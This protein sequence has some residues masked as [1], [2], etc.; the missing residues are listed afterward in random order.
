MDPLLSH[1]IG[2]YRIDR[3][4]GEGGMGRVYSG[5]NVVSRRVVAIKVIADEHANSADLVGRFYAEAEA[6]S[7]IRHPG[8]VEVI[9]LVYLVDGR[10]AIV[11]ELL[12]GRTLRALL[13]EQ[14]LPISLAIDLVGQVLDA[15]AAAHAAGIVHRDLKPDNIVVDEHHRVKVL[16][17]GIAKLTGEAMS[18]P[19]PRTRTGMM[20]GTPEY[21][22][23]EQIT[24]SSIDARTDI[25]SIGVVLYEVLTGRRPFSA[26][27]QFE[28]LRAHLETPPPI[29]Q[30]AGLGDTHVQVLLRAL[31]KLPAA[32]FATANEMAAAL[33]AANIGTSV[34]I[35][36]VPPLDHRP[37]RWWPVAAVVVFVA[38]GVVAGVV[39]KRHPQTNVSERAPAPVSPPSPSS[40]ARTPPNRDV[41]TYPAPPRPE[42]FDASAFL[43]DATRYARA[44]L[45]DAEPIQGHF[46]AVKSDG[47]LDL[48]AQPENPD[49]LFWS[50]ATS[51]RPP[52]LASNQEFRGACAVYVDISTAHVQAIHTQTICDRTSTPAPRCTLRQLWDRAAKKGAD[53]T[54]VADIQFVEGRWYFRIDAKNLS[55]QFHDDC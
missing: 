11:M 41:E 13:A 22:A 44:I 17:F 12:D 30:R 5:T 7:R 18:T 48:S 23:P 21:M 47:S 45:P 29:P 8:I 6:A 19:A 14:L 55:L 35:A 38:T 53:R 9:D 10:P 46:P 40:P 27:N 54:L 52:N 34:P 25:Y 37:R 50:P 16:D 28:I 51:S 24:G 39:A 43:V 33:R 31:A 36:T 1:Q 42:A 49:W 26:D 32:R 4:L 20:L 2:N 15:V 3:L